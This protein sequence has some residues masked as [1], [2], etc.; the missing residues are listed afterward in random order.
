VANKY[1]TGFDQ[2]LLHTMYV[3]K[4]L[5][6][7][8]AVQTLSR[9][10]RTT[11]GKTD[12]FVLDFAN[13]TDEIKDAFEPYYETTILGEAT[14][15]NKLFD[16]QNALDAY[17][18][19]TNR[20]VHDFS[21]KI[22]QNVSVDQLHIILDA[23]ADVFRT[24]LDEIS[25]EDFR[26]KCKSYIRLYVFLVQILPFTNPYLERLYVFLNHLQNKI[27]KEQDED[28]ASGVTNTIDLDSY[29]LLKQ[30]EFTITLQ[31]GDELMPASEMGSGV[32]EPELELLSNIVKA[33]NDRFGTQFT[34]ED[35]VRKMAADLLQDVQ[36]DKAA[37]DNISA[38]LDKNDIQNA[39][40]TF[41]ETLK[42]KMINHIDSNF[43]VFKEYNENP[44]F[45]TLLVGSM[46]KLMHANFVNRTFK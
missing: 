46:F 3:D 2:P 32:A 31:Q 21:D 5:G 43:E 8:N 36:D 23:A 38:S 33:F 45:R 11:A 34:N 20:Q 25:Q 15:P 29:R 40:I 28:L 12:T 27:Q 10:N 37:M 22:V 30:G 26:A 24:T 39:H 16:L 6:G 18:V 7:V 9:L 35:K 42:E 17:Q 41:A 44:E 13:S 1:Q 19:Y 14:D 4:K